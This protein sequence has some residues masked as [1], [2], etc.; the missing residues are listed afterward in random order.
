MLVTLSAKECAEMLKGISKQPV[1][2]VDNHVFVWADERW[3]KLPFGY[4]GYDEPVNNV[5]KLRP[6]LGEEMVT[7]NE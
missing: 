1:T 5:P 6:T 2:V 7:V 3:N 4:V